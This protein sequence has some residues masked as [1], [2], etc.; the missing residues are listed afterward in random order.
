MREPL[1]RP[2]STCFHLALAFSGLF[3]YTVIFLLISETKTLLPPH[4]SFFLCVC[5][6]NGGPCGRPRIQ[7][8]RLSSL[9][10][11]S[12]SLPHTL[13]PSPLYITVFK[14]PSPKKNPPP[15]HKQTS[16]GSRPSSQAHCHNSIFSCPRACPLTAE[17]SSPKPLLASRLSHR[18]PFYS[19]LRLEEDLRVP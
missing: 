7:L 4:G 16:T 18:P 12:F 2:T 1:K 19:T 15:T 10:A 8:R 14:I 11:R 3:I 13:I 5:A 6:L 17:K 9:S